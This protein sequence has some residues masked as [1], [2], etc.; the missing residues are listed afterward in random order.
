MAE[1]KTDPRTF[2]LQLATLVCGVVGGAVCFLVIDRRI[3]DVDV[4]LKQAETESKELEV[5]KKKTPILG[6]TGLIQMQS[7]FYRSDAG[8]PINYVVLEVLLENLGFSPIGLGDITIEVFEAFAS[9]ELEEVLQPK[10]PEKVSPLKTD[11]KDEA[12]S[13][14][15]HVDTDVDPLGITPPTIAVGDNAGKLFPVGSSDHNWSRVDSLTKKQP[16]N[17]ELDQSQKRTVQFDFV[18]AESSKP[19]WYRFV[20]TVAPPKSDKT[21]NDLRIDTIMSGGGLPLISQTISKRV[22]ETRTAPP[23]FGERMAPQIP[24]PED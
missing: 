5:A 12:T 4:R 14:F 6:V 11:P 23:S 21:W 10:K 7:A 13:V 1:G 16:L 3:A 22:F 8:S 24:L 2:Y 19:K 15:D 20:I 9:K 17:Y 18:M